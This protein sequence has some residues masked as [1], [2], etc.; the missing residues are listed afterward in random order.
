MERINKR[1]GQPV[2]LKPIHKLKKG[3]FFRLV[4]GVAVYIYEGYCR[5][6]KRYCGTNESNIS[7]QLYKR[8]GAII[9]TEF[10]Y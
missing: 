5:Q 8:K 2:T 6:N 9:E 10:T 1:T 7:K 4:N 3:D